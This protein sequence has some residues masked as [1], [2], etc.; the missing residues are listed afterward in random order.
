MRALAAAHPAPATV[1]RRLD[2]LESRDGLALIAT[3]TYA[4][5]DPATGCVCLARAGHPPTVLT[6][7]GRR[8]ELLQPDGAAIG[9]SAGPFTEQTV[10]LGPD[11]RLIMYTDGLG[12]RRDL[13]P[14]EQLEH[15]LAA[16]T[17]LA[18]L[19]PAEL[20]NALMNHLRLQC[21]D[22]AGFVPVPTRTCLRAPSLSR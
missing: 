6:R 22:V 3:V 21:G 7:P 11:G 13:T 20:P 15:L 12:E 17:G 10:Q 2:E 16:V 14:D 9:L 19:P 1:L 4:V 18:H 5:L 8:P